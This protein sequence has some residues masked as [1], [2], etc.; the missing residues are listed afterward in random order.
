MTFDSFQVDVKIEEN[1]LWCEIILEQEPKYENLAYA[2][3]LLL[4]GS[5]IKVSSYTSSNQ[6]QFPLIEDGKYKVMGFVRQGEDRFTNMSNEIE[7]TFDNHYPVPTSEYEKNPISISIFGSCVTRDV[8]E[9]DRRKRLKLQTYIARQ[10]IVSAVEKSVD[11]NMDD[12]FLNSKF[13]K[14]CVYN[15]FKKNAFEFFNKDGSKY[16]IIDLID[17]RFKLVKCK[18][19]NSLVTYST[20]LQ[21]SNHIKNPIFVEKKKSIFNGKKYYVD[22][23]P[24]E[25]YLGKF[26]SKIKAIYFEDHI[27]IHKCKMAQFYIDKE[28]NTKKFDESYLIY[29]KNINELLEY[30]YS[31]LECNL[32]QAMVINISDEYLADEQHKWGLSPMHYQ[33]EYYI[34][35]FSK[36]EKYVTLQQS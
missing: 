24:L 1:K 30:M 35:V 36:I 31:Y 2:F 32:P 14:Q 17:E 6:A 13:Q 7:F 15:D 5:K 28:G 33:K 20:Y 26:C 8:L 9:Y 10:S 22:G 23:M 21:E 18:K 19:E 11:I 34:S 27:I 25:N 12:I 16:L 3:Y 29:N 4:N